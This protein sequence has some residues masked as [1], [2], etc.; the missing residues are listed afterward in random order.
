MKHFGKALLSGLIGAVLASTWF[1]FSFFQ[2]VLRVDLLFTL[3]VAAQ[4]VVLYGSLRA[5]PVAW[6]LLAAVVATVLAIPGSVAAI[7]PNLLFSRWLWTVEIPYEV[8]GESKWYI[9][10]FLIVPVSLSILVRYMWSNN[11]WRGP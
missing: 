10:A 6:S 4:T 1:R 11:R 7:D 3:L 2:S 8:V 9:A 5:Q